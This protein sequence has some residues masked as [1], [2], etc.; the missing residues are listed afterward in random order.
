[1]TS[2]AH[3]RFPATAYI[4]RTFAAAPTVS[5]GDNVTPPGW[6]SRPASDTAGP[7]PGPAAAIA[8][9]TPVASLTAATPVPL[10]TIV[11]DVEPITPDH[12]DVICAPTPIAGAAHLDP[13]RIFSDRSSSTSR[14]CASK[15]PLTGI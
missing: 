11:R 13:P 4:A 6:N 9:T 14:F 15:T 5:V 3:S 10:P 2:I 7:P 12:S 8:V 1:L